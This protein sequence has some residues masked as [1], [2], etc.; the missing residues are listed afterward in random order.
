MDNDGRS[1]P[2]CAYTM[3]DT[4]IAAQLPEP[5]SSEELD[6]FDQG[7]E[8]ARAMEPEPL[9]SLQDAVTPSEPPPQVDEGETVDD[10]PASVEDGEEPTEDAADEDKADDNAAADKDDAPADQ[11]QQDATPRQ[12]KRFR[13]LKEEIESIKPLAE[14]AREWEQTIQSTGAS[15]EQFGN[16]LNYL[17]AINSG[18]PAQMGKAYET[19]QAE[20]AWL[21]KQLGKPAPGYD[22]LTE[23]ADLQA[24]IEQG[25]LSREAAQE[26]IAARRQQKIYTQRQQQTLQQQQQQAAQQQALDAVAALGDR[27]RAQDGALF[28]ARFK[29]IEPMVTVI[30]DSLPPA[31]W[32]AAIEKAYQ[33]APIIPATP[34]APAPNPARTS[35]APPL[36]AV[37][38]P[39]DAF[40]YGV[41]QAR[42]QGL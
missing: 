14:R 38:N 27:L 39:D 21:G 26:L 22:P 6:A 3:S 5:P 25:T 24:Q 37:P 7:V 18:D 13:E 20:L 15:P 9:P 31:Q 11:P 4:A 41:E 19:M 1:I 34:R 36:A 10:A 2:R 42:Q 16:M 8:A 30:Q 29:A 23:H 12:Q 40:A 35:S 33:A 28:K 32:A 17:T